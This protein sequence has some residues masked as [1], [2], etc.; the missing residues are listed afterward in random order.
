MNIPRSWS[1]KFLCVVWLLA[2]NTLIA[3][4]QIAAN[5]QE[6]ISGRFN[7]VNHRGDA[8]TEASYA[9]QYRLVFFGFT[10]CPDICPTTMSRMGQMMRQLSAEQSKDLK[11]LFISVDHENDSVARLAQYVSHFHPSI[12]GLT[13]TEEQIREAAEGFN[14]T[15]G[16]AANAANGYDT[17]YH[18]SYIYL[19]DKKGQLLD[20]FSHASSTETLVEHLSQLI[21]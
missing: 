20:L 12:D 15:F 11:I 9:G 1:T 2:S 7:L 21:R 19:M 3:N 17:Y 8:V 14:S 13:G 18:S 6:P 4:E 16:K 10:N 5:I